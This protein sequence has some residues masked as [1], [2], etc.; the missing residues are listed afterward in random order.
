MR[1]KM[2]WGTVLMVAWTV[3]APQL[4][5]AGTYAA[6]FLRIG[7]GARPAAMGGAF[8]ALANDG[9]AFYWNPAGLA[10]VRRAELTFEHTPMFGGIAQYNVASVALR[11]MPG[12][13]V[14]LSWIR[15]GVEDIPRYGELAETRWDRFTNPALR[16]TGQPEGYFGDSENAIMLSF[17]RKLEFELS[18]GVGLSRVW[19]PAELCVG[20]TYKYLEQHLD[21]FSGHGQ[22][23]DAGVL[24]RL[25]TEAESAGQPVR[26]VG[27]GVGVRDLSRTSLKWNSPA[28]T[29]DRT[30]PVVRCGVAFTQSLRFLKS[31]AGLALDKEY[32]GAEGVYVGGELAVANVVALRVGSHD[33]DLAV[34]AGLRLGWVHID[35]A[36]VSYQLRGTHRV[37]AAMRL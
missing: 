26:S 8:V 2:W 15:L 35:Y 7:V 28:R 21:A 14:G 24:L 19:I 27:L 30:Q 6:E 4:L 22:G 12:M 5:L 9:T 13:A 36:F 16:S 17:A 25:T 23:L 18:L 11:L 29:I 33:G 10:Y 20:A 31:Q 32:F 37:S 1:A 34:G 3:F